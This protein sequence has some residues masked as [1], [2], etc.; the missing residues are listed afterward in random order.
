MPVWP[1]DPHVA[2]RTISKIEEG[3]DA[4]VTEIQMSVHTGTHI[5]AASHFIESGQTIEEIPFDKLIGEVL[6]LNI[7]PSEKSISDHVL[8][9]HLHFEKIIKAKKILFKTRNSKFLHDY[10]S[11]FQPDYVGINTSG[12]EFLAQLDLDLVGVDYLSIAPFNETQ[13]PHQLLLSKEIVLLEGID[14]S[15]VNEGV[16]Q[17]YCLPLN[18]VGC[19][20]AP[21]RVILI[22]HLDD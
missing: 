10:P 7:D 2:L 12:A 22:D 21:A 16:Y 6:V 11:E 8:K 1:G 3:D 15:S 17:L 20:G 13:R 19:E 18:L 4:T 5:D 9:T 14:L